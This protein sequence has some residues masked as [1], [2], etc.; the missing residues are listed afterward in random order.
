[1]SLRDHYRTLIAVRKQVNALRAGDFRVLLA[2]DDKETVVIGRKTGTQAALTLVNRSTSA[3]TISVPLSGYIHDG[4][5]FTALFAVGNA[6]GAMFTTSGGT[7][8]ATLQPESGLLL[9]TGTVDLTPPDPPQ[10]LKV[11]KEGSQNVELSWSAS[12]EAAGYNVY[13]SVVSGGGWEKANAS[14]ITTTNYKVQDL[15]DGN[16]YYFIVKALDAVGNESDASNEVSGI[17]HLS[18]GWANLQWPPTM[19]HT[20]SASTPTDLAYGQ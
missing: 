20:I 18:I 10:G 7:L 8:Q 13:R 17:P 19:T 5:Q 9:A 4:V 11:T 12:A 16:T 15:T 3:Q 1:Y 6:T 2:D 14:L